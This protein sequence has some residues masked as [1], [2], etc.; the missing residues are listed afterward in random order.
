MKDDVKGLKVARETETAFYSD[1]ELNP[2]SWRGAPRSSPRSSQDEP[3]SG[4]HRESAGTLM[5]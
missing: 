3:L 2:K 1:G 4:I 5:I